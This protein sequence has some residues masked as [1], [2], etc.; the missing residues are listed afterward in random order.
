MKSIAKGR[1]IEVVASI[2]R[3][4]LSAARPRAFY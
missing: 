3:E 1:E 2:G 4:R